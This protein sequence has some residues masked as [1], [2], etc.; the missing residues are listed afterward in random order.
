MAGHVHEG[1]GRETAGVVT[2][3]IPI[4]VHPL[5]HVVGEGVLEVGRA[6]SVAVEEV[7][8]VRIG[9]AVVTD[10]VAV[11]VFR[12]TRVVGKGIGVVAHAIAVG[13]HGLVGVKGEGIAVVANAIAVAVEVFEGV[14]GEH[15]SV[16]ADPVVVGIHR[17]VGVVGEGVTVVAHAIAVRIHPFAAVVGEHVA[18]I[19]HAVAV[20]VLPFVGVVREVIVLVAVA[21]AVSVWTAI[22][23]NRGGPCD[24]GTIIDGVEDAVHVDVVGGDEQEAHAQRVLGAVLAPQAQVDRFCDAA[25]RGRGH[26]DG[27][28]VNHRARHHAVGTKVNGDFLLEVHAARFVGVLEVL[29]CTVVIGDVNHVVMVHKDVVVAPYITNTVDSG[30][31]PRLP[32][33]H[34]LMT[35]I[36]AVVKRAVNVAKVVGHHSEIGVASRGGRLAPSRSR[37]AGGVFVLASR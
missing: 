29:V 10:T 24:V 35:H 7:V 32:G 3:P 1:I 34:H 31:L 21:V 28:V 36:G 11:G 23:V 5:C 27:R 22:S 37:I 33:H 6:I 18:V 20:G 15:V 12:F 9:V 26:H 16:I 30:G 8:D 25:G 13:I 19:A 2:V 14:V 4:A 17:F